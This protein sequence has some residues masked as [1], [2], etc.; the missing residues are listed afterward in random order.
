MTVKYHVPHLPM[1]GKG[2]MLLDV[3]DATG[4][5]TGFQ[6]LGNVSTLDQEEKD[7][8]AE[9]FQ[10]IN[11]IPTLIATAVRKSQCRSSSERPH[12]SSR[13]LQSTSEYC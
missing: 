11:N 1:L 9:L 8:K 12:A 6:H 7:D 2:S 10:H 4:A 5:S 3:F 13:P